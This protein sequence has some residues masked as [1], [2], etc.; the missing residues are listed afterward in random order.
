MR[1]IKK[2]N[3]CSCL[4]YG[5]HKSHFTIFRALW[6]LSASYSIVLQMNQSSSVHFHWP[7]HLLFKIFSQRLPLLKLIHV[8]GELC[9]SLLHL[10]SGLQNPRGVE[11]ELI[12]IMISLLLHFV[13]RWC[14]LVVI[15]NSQT[16]IQFQRNQSFILVCK[17]EILHPRAKRSLTYQFNH[18]ARCCRV[19]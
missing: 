1:I 18:T 11:V 6:H 12:F 16:Y 7:C 17:L 15:V 2:S 5:V 19:L 10:L 4:I 3:Q 13:V 14:Q 9:C 8:T